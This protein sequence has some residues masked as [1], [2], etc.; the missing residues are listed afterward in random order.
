MPWRITW[1]PGSLLLCKTNFRYVET[2]R[3]G[4]HLLLQH[5]LAWLTDADLENRILVQGISENLDRSLDFSRPQFPH[6]CSEASRLF[7]SD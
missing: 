2:L 6:V 7:A 1:T 3:C 4:A 5:N